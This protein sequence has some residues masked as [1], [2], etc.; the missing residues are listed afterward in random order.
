MKKSYPCV[1]CGRGTV[2]PTYITHIVQQEKGNLHI[3]GVPVG[4]C[5]RCGQQYYN[6]KVLARIGELTLQANKNRIRNLLYT[7]EYALPGV[8]DAC[9][10]EEIQEEWEEV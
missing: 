7:N 5:P 10:A 6:N 2:R 4:L 3:K 1:E 9:P 8:P